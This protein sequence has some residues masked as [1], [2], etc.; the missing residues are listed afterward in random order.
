MKKRSLLGVVV[1]LLV[2]ANAVVFFESASA[3][4]LRIPDETKQCW[5]TTHTV[6]CAHYFQDDCDYAADCRSQEF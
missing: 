2:A 6:G 5:W 1:A 3:V 4:D